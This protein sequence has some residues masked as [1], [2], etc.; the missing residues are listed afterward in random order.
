MYPFGGSSKRPE[1]GWS[2]SNT[3]KR[4]AF[5]ANSTSSFVLYIDGNLISTVPFTFTSHWVKR[6][7]HRFKDLFKVTGCKV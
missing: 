4:K 7:S 5:L 6:V 1:C 3:V 2:E